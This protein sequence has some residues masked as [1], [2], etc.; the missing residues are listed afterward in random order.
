M[1]I[2]ASALLALA[3]G[4]ASAARADSV[5]PSFA[6]APTGW[7]VDRQAPVSF[8]DVGTFQGM[9]HV[10]GI[11]IGTNA[12]SDPFYNTQG[13][14]HPVSGGA[15]SSLIANLYIPSSWSSNSSAP[16]R[17]DMWGVLNA[18]NPG[19]SNLTYPIIGFTNY[20]SVSGNGN[21]GTA[22]NSYTGFRVYDETTGLWVNLSTVPVQYD[23]WN[24]LEIDFN[25]TSFDYSV[26]DAPVY[27]DG[28]TETATDFT[29]VIMQ[30]YDF[31]GIAGVTA[32]P[33]EAD[34]ANAPEPASL[35]VLGVG[36][37]GLGIVRRRKSM[38]PR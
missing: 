17:T 1:R 18:T 30:G 21:N 27:S 10:L 34:W 19:D 36:L 7:T 12:T 22:G 29:S 20:G 5:M 9:P 23:A 15:G 4:G 33:Y 38:A 26:N 25:G 32:T 37:A 3:I 13:E 24:K 2:L 11:S 6:G 16:V 8:S 31:N 35:L 14:S 28:T